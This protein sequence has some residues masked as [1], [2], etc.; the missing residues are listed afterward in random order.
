MCILTVLGSSI[1]AGDY[2]H[3]NFPLDPSDFVH[4]RKRIG[5]EEMKV[6]LRQR[7]DHFA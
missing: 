5:E 3:H 6:I 1:S 7:I 2:F 4:F